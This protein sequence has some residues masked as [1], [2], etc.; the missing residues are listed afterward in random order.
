MKFQLLLLSL[1]L[2]ACESRNA[3]LPD[4][5]PKEVVAAGGEK[6]AS[7]DFK[8]F[9]PYLDRGTD[10]VYVINFWATW[11]APCVKELPHFKAAAAKFDKDNVRVILVSLDMKREVQGTLLPFIRKHGLQ[12]LALHLHEPDADAWI[13]KV[14]PKWSGALPATL[15]YSKDRREFYERSFTADELEKEIK[16]FIK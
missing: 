3:T 5:R 1:A 8:S 11:C 6:I 9:E 16:S 4:P 15:I 14:S 10:S 12:D 7:Y 13:P 2:M